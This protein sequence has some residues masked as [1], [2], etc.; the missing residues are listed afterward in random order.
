MSYGYSYRL[1]VKG[2]SNDTASNVGKRFAGFSGVKVSAG[3]DWPDSHESFYTV[4]GSQDLTNTLNDWFIEDYSAER[5]D[6][7]FPIGSLLYWHEL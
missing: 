2:A 5:A 6:T 7:Q 4:V 1:I 3:T